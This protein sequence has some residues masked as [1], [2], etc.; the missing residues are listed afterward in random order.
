MSSVWRLCV[1][2]GVV[3]TCWGICDVVRN[4]VCYRIGAVSTV[5]VLGLSPWHWGVL[6]DKFKF[7]T[8]DLALTVKSLLTTL[9]VKSTNMCIE[10]QM[11]KK[12]YSIYSVKC[13]VWGEPVYNRPTRV[14]ELMWMTEYHLIWFLRY[15]RIPVVIF[16]AP[17]D[18]VKSSSRLR[19]TSKWKGRCLWVFV[20][21]AYFSCK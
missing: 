17:H 1:C 9:C 19:L 16:L 10:H 20:Q 15:S 7:L 12:N 18:S 8:F 6:E 21:V 5:G 13:A 11:K 2:V 3:K 14:F 4:I